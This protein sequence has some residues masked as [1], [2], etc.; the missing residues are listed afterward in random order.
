L[1]GQHPET[2]IK[3]IRDSL[4]HRYPDTTIRLYQHAA[5][6]TDLAVH[7]H[8]AGTPAN[9]VVTELGAR[10]A[11]GLREYGMVEHTVWI[12]QDDEDID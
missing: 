4:A 10:F 2:L 1:T 5:V 7:I 3:E 12:E 8:I 6:E 9:P 11:S